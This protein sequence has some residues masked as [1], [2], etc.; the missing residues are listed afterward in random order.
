MANRHDVIIWEAEAYGIP[1]NFDEALSMAEKLSE[2]S[3]SVIS[4]KVL[5]F[6]K[7]IEKIAKKNVKEDSYWQ[8]YTELVKKIK[9]KS[10]A[11]YVIAMPECAGSDF[12][13][14]EVVEAAV[15]HQLVA[16]DKEITTIF[17]PNDEFL[18]PSQEHMWWAFVDHLENDDF[19]KN[20][21]Q[22]EKYCTPLV[23]AMFAKYG[24]TEKRL[25]GEKLRY[26]LDFK[27]FSISMEFGYGQNKSGSFGVNS[28]GYI[29]SA[30]MTVIYN[31]F[32]FH[33]REEVPIHNRDNFEPAFTS[34][35][36]DIYTNAQLRA[37]LQKQERKIMLM[38]GIQDLASLDNLVNGN[39]YPSIRETLH[40][41]VYAPYCAILGRLAD[42]PDF[43]GLVDKL[44]KIT[45]WQ[46][47]TPAKATEW[48]KLAQY[49]REEVQPLE[50]RSEALPAKIRDIPAHIKHHLQ[51]VLIDYQNTNSPLLEWPSEL[52]D[53]FWLIEDNHQLIRFLQFGLTTTLCN[54]LDEAE[55]AYRQLNN[56]INTEEDCLISREKQVLAKYPPTYAAIYHI[57]EFFAAYEVHGASLIGSWGKEG[58]KEVLFSFVRLGL[59]QIGRAYHV[60]IENTPKYNPDIENADFFYAQLCQE[61]IIAGFETVMPFSITQ[62]HIDVAEAVRKNFYAFLV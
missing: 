16:C 58:M 47:N 3:V 51:Q 43:E 17:L 22:F 39:T 10:T 29:T 53:K 26:V 37:A 34:A 7:D 13:L 2:Q 11:A 27:D 46:I 42:N 44:D 30:P 6:A 28:L 12:V 49:L 1:A 15:K 57:F 21:K 14:K 48:P 23:D 40:H 18:P 36:R 8:R 56:N 20:E 25:F 62:Q 35:E 50:K 5:A 4:E 54:L 59:D 45:G 32:G 60:G 52:N 38:S 24:F 31:R 19:P 41:S 9:Q 33:K 61:K 55:Q